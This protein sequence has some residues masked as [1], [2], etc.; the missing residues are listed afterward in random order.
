[1]IYFIPAWYSENDWKENE[2]IWYRR[3]MHTEVDDT[4]KQL[5]LFDRKSSFDSKTMLLQYS[6][7][8]RHF[9]HRQGLL[10]SAYWSVFDVI[11]NIH[12]K[13]PAVLSFHDLAWPENIEFQYTP[14]DIV[15]F[16]ENEKYATIEFGEDGNMI[17]V[18]LY[19]HNE[20]RRKNIYDDRGFLSSTI[21]YRNQTWSY[22]QYLDESGTWR[23]C[24]YADG[25]VDVNPTSPSYQIEYENQEYSYSFQKQTYEDI[26]E[27]IEEVF[28]NY[29]Q[30]QEDKDIY[31]IAMHELHS[32]LIC[33]VLQNQKKILSFYNS[34]CV[35]T[36]NESSLKLVKQSECVIVNSKNVFERI[37][38]NEISTN[39]KW[40]DITPFDSRVDFGHSLQLKQQNILIPI[41]ALED[42]LFEDLIVILMHY[43]HENTNVRVNLFTRK[44]DWNQETLLL[45]KTQKILKKYKYDP[46]YARQQSHQRME[47]NLE[48]EVPILFTVSQCVDEL[49]V[50]K[51]LKQQRLIVDLE[52][53]LDLFLQI[54]AISMGVPQVVMHE[55]DYVVDGKNGI[56]LKDFNELE[57]TLHFYLDTLKNWNTAMIESYELGKKFSSDNLLKQ[58]EG[59]IAYVQKC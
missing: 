46:N 41:D 47:N 10:H 38:L 53:N 17:Q 23:I 58:W 30:L 29:V 8:Y 12:M 18:D 48:E 54:S 28:R 4:V 31:C 57:G 1:M 33:N 52:T 14:F 32:K 6:P 16:K 26:S 40:T 49:S 50:S 20:L 5:Q 43:M 2:Q 22:Q 3:R 59:V 24:R 21:V 25:H 11:Q 37:G 36:N 44:S 45:E 15:A 39:A 13:R 51:C 27:I 56:V 42:K 9:L 55:T 7:N 34:R 19:D 35:P